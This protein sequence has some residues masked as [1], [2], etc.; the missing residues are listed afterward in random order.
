MSVCIEI[1]GCVLRRD[2]NQALH[3]DYLSN[4]CNPLVPLLHTSVIQW[5]IDK[6]YSP[7]QSEYTNR[8]N[9]KLQ[10][11]VHHLP[12]ASTDAKLEDALSATKQGTWYIG[13]A[14][15]VHKCVHKEIV[16]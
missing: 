6:G 14:L 4:A 5:A 8:R 10:Y 7:H 1:T 2:F 11:Q 3:C 9:N 15:V 16:S 12:I 13:M